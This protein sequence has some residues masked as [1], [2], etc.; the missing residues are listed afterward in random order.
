MYD[1]KFFYIVELNLSQQ[2]IQ[3][4]P[5]AQE[6]EGQ[7]WL[8]LTSSSYTDDATCIADC[9]KFMKQK[10]KF[11]LEDQHVKFSYAEN[12]VLNCPEEK[13]DTLETDFDENSLV[14]MTITDIDGMW[15]MRAS[16]QVFGIDHSSINQRRLH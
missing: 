2:A 13:L 4:L 1:L 11:F 7:S 6:F 5:L 12:P 14:A 8:S 16:V 10:T 3:R 15:I 9:M